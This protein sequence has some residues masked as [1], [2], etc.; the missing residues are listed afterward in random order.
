MSAS[1]S[2]GVVG[3]PGETWR[4]KE[5]ILR[6]MQHENGRREWRER[7]EKLMKATS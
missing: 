1:V 7:A 4:Q 6:H 5:K 3:S 2:R